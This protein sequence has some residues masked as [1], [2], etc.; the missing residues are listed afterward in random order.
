MQPDAKLYQEAS[1]TLRGDPSSSHVGGHGTTHGP[2]NPQ[3]SEGDRSY[4]EMAI[5]DGD[6]LGYP[7]VT[8]LPAKRRALIVAPLYFD[9][10]KP[11]YE[12]YKDAV[13]VHQVLV[14][15]QGYERRNIRILIDDFEEEYSGITCL[16]RANVLKSLD[17]L[18]YEAQPTDFRFFHF[19]GHGERYLSERGRGKEGR[20][21]PPDSF[22]A[23]GDD[24]EQWAMTKQPHEIKRVTEQTI[25]K[26]ELVYYSEAILMTTSFDLKSRASGHKI[27]DMELNHKFSSLP[28]GCT[29]TC[30]MD[31]CASGRILNNLIKLE[32]NCFRAPLEQG[33]SQSGGSAKSEPPVP[34]LSGIFAVNNAFQAVVNMGKNLW[35]YHFSDTVTMYEELPDEE[36]R[37]DGIVAEA[38]TW[39]A[40]HTR[41]SAGP[42]FGDF[43]CG[44][45]TKVGPPSIASKS[46]TE[47]W[48]LAY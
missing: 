44:I 30:V 47:P 22:N 21:V 15:T 42:S 28:I 7:N 38:R 3:V 8:P 9:H 6:R 5:Q 45:L 41:Q 17:W 12:T 39:A 18:T 27:T 36:A 10:E 4:I 34:L 2:K 1:V 20:R 16:T 40:C 19:S 46:G 43:R 14:E 37:L 13:L 29:L 11:M 33:L 26:S 25:P 31:C 23:A 35:N 32:G 24:H 48:S